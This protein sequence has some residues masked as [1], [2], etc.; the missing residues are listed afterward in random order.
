MIAILMTHQ[1][2]T[3]SSSIN[4]Y[5][6]MCVRITAVSSFW[7]FLLLV[8]I[9]GTGASQEGNEHRRVTW[10]TCEPLKF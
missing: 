4:R 6:R 10:L 3:R 8:P 2:L 9:Y 1:Q 7:A 5:I